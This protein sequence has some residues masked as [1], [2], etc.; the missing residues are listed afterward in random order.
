MEPISWIAL[1]PIVL[2][3]IIQE[4]PK[5]IAQYKL[6]AKDKKYENKVELFNEA[7]KKY[8]KTKVLK[9]LNDLAK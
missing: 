4:V 2:K 7:V 5:F 8:K 9:D 3:F 1:I 6:Y